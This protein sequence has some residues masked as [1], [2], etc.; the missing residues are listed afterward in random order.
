MEIWKVPFEKKPKEGSVR[1]AKP[2]WEWRLLP[3][4]TTANEIRVMRKS[5]V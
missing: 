3:F 4:R 1:L 2:A 5:I